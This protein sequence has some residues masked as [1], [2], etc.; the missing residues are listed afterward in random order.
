MGLSEYLAETHATMSGPELQERLV[1]IARNGQKMSNII[2]ELL[3]FASMN[4]E[5]VELAPVEMAPWWSALHRLYYTIQEAQAKFILPIG[6]SS[7]GGAGG[8]SLV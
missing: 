2:T 1:S 5:E 3:L 4:K 8:R 7:P 6:P